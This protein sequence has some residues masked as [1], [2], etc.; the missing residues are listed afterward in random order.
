M[1]PQKGSP[2]L[3]DKLEDV[4]ARKTACRLLI[5]VRSFM[6]P[7]Q[8]FGL[9]STVHQVQLDLKTICHPISFLMGIGHITLQLLDCNASLNIV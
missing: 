7:S 4:T 5:P 6:R 1:L 8:L 2:T 9:Q 3:G